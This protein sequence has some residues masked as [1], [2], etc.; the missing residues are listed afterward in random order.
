VR[1]LTAWSV[2]A[3]LVVASCLVGAV[4]PGGERRRQRCRGE[5]TF[6]VGITNEVD[7][8]NPFLGIEAESYEMW[9]LAYDYLITYSMED[10]SPQ[11]GLAESWETSDDGLTWTFEVREGVTWSD[12]E[13]LSADDIAATYE[14]IL[15][16]GPEAATWRSCL[17]KVQR[18]SAPD[19]TTLVLEPASPTPCC[20]C[21][22][23]LPLL[24]I[25][26]VPEHVWGSISESVVK[27]Y[28]NEPSEDQPVVGSGPYAWSRA[29]PAGRPTCSRPTRTTGRLRRA[30]TGS[31]SGST[32][33]RTRWCRPS[34]RARSTSPRMCPRCRSRPSRAR[35]DRHVAGRLA[36]LRRDR[37]QHRLG[38]PGHRRTHRG[39]QPRG[40]RPPLPYALGFALDR[41][42]IA[43]R[44]YQGGAE[45]GDTI[46]PATYPTYH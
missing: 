39:S 41:E 25:L 31:S 11:P 10:M 33:P 35:G 37:L 17:A 45:P 18:I 6:T 44:I 8:F 34:S 12:G 4:T 30:S 23:V 22:A 42:L 15:D 19:P 2:A 40:A 16:G 28:P 43:E 9:A 7:S 21:C 38:G 24:P 20:R 32:R 46:V 3:L 29:R 14:R 36:R 1:R 13:P 27:S 5:T 26:I